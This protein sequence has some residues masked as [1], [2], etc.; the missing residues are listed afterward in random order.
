M[1]SQEI[2]KDLTKVLV[3]GIVFLARASSKDAALKTTLAAVPE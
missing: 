1:N 2:H 3:S